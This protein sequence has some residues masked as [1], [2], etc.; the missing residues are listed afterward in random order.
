M[1][2]FLPTPIGNLQDITLHTLEVLR[3]S[4]ILLCEDTRVTK[5]LIQLLIKRSLLPNKD[6]IYYALHTHNE[7]KFL[8]QTPLEFFS[9]KIAVLTDAGMPCISDPGVTLVRHLQ[10]HNLCFEVVGGISAL[11]LIVALSGIVE[12]EFTFL[13]F[14]PHKERKAYFATLLKSPYPV[15]LYESPRRLINALELMVQYDR[16]R[17]VFI[18]KEL[19][20]KYQQTFKGNI[21]EVLEELQCSN[22]ALRGEWAMVIDK[23]Q[24]ELQ[25]PSL[26]Q[27]ALLSLE[28]PPKIKAKILAKI[29]GGKAGD[30]YRD[31]IE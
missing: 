15:V 13:G 18:A 17:I 19:T 1:V 28:I 27:E 2:T 7:K 11:T 26:T 23:S 31:L 14:A 12:K 22:Q 25:S 6:Y 10:A 24:Q 21:Q 29:T 20:K 30:Y 8:K 5:S 16:T 4:D 9:Q 3:E